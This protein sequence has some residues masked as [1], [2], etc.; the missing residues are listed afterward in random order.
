MEM[1][2]Q[3]LHLNE[4]SVAIKITKFKYMGLLRLVLLSFHIQQNKLLQVISFQSK[5]P[6]TPSESEREN[7][8]WCL[9]FFLWS[10]IFFAFA[11]SRCEWTLTCRCGHNKLELRIFWEADSQFGCNKYK[12]AVE[13]SSDI[14]V[15]HWISAEYHTKM[16]CYYNVVEPC[17]FFSIYEGTDSP[18][19]FAMRV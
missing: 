16:M 12:R 5:G 9:K 14:F 3:L 13:T 11:F 2:L 8:L 4:Q 17:Q 19:R 7:V 6:F 18:I 10:L 1:F 15:T